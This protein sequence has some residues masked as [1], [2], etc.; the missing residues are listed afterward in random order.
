VQSVHGQGGEHRVHTLRTPGGVQG[1]RALAAQV[2]HLQRPGEGDGQDVPLMKRSY[3][4][5]PAAQ[6]QPPE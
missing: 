3:R 6:D 4:D 1:V 2:P 5:Q